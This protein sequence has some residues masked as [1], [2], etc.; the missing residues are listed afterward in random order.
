MEVRTCGTHG[1]NMDLKGTHVVLSPVAQ[2]QQ[3]SIERTMDGWIQ[4]YSLTGLQQ[5]FC[6]MLADKKVWKN[7]MAPYHPCT[8]PMQVLT[9]TFN[10]RSYNP[11]GNVIGSKLILHGPYGVTIKIG[12]YGDLPRVEWNSCEIIL[13]E[14]FVKLHVHQQQDPRLSLLGIRLLYAAN[15]SETDIITELDEEVQL[16]K[17]EAQYKILRYKLGVGEGVIEIPTGNCFPLEANCD[18]LHGVSFHKGCYIGQELTARTHHTGVVRKRLMP[19]IFD[20]VPKN[21]LEHDA[22]ILAASGVP[23]KPIG[24]LRGVERN[25]GIGLLRVSEALDSETLQIYDGTGH[26]MKPFWWPQEA[27]K[28]RV[29]LVK[30]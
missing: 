9:C 26:T 29:S 23:K 12:P 15:K 24:K 7:Q 1:R 3:G 27:P 6:L 17:D 2:K 10:P 11:Q 14:E 25:V 8:Q 16:P 28:E 19:L 5:C 21:G 13:N 18:Y 30:R 22:P 20:L 4:L